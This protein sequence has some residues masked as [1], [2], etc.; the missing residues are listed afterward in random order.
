V[1][2]W[3]AGGLLDLVGDAADSGQVKVEAVAV[4]AMSRSESGKTVTR[5]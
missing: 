1:T 4:G 3:A 2:P 5:R